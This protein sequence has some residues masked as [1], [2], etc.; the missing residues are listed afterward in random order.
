MTV[1]EKQIN[2]IKKVLALDK[3]NV[4]VHKVFINKLN[5]FHKHNIVDIIQVYAADYQGRKN[6]SFANLKIVHFDET[7]IK[8]TYIRGIKEEVEI[9][10]D[11]PYDFLTAESADSIFALKDYFEEL[12]LSSA[13][14][15]ERSSKKVDS[16]TY[17]TKS[18]ADFFLFL[19]IQLPLIGSILFKAS[20]STGDKIAYWSNTKKVTIERSLNILAVLTILIHIVEI[21]VLKIFKLWDYHRVPMDLKIEHFIFSM[22]EGFPHH[23][24]FN[25]IIEKVTSS[26]FYELDIDEVDNIM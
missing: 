3:T 22:L 25:R 24:R 2:S 14:K 19:L 18:V 17:P 15:M 26:G 13:A 5:K 8:F 6:I 9:V 16:I 10:I 23:K 21:V 20:S 4:N 1:T 11:T 12:S 7:Q